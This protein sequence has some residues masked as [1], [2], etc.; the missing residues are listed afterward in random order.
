MFYYLNCNEQRSCYNESKRMSES[1][2]AAFLAEKKM[3]YVTARICRVYGPTLKADD[4]KAMSQFLRNA[5]MGRDIILKSDGNQYFSYIYS[6]DAASA[7]LYILINGKS[8]ECYNVADVDSKIT[9][10]DLAAKISKYSKTSVVFK[11]PDTKEY[12]GYSKAI[13][14]VLNTNKINLLGWKSQFHIDTA[15]ARTLELMNL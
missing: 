7:L 1:L 2:C 10:K 6:A 3:D 12:K 4:S 15:I 11:I 8:G 14:S 9:L 5:S 13:Y